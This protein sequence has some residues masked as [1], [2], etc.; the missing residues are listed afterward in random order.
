MVQ[1]PYSF[2]KS[3]GAVIGSL[4]DQPDGSKVC[5]NQLHL[6]VD[7]QPLWWNGGLLR[8]KNKSIYLLHTMLKV[9][10]GIFNHHA[11]KIPTISASYPLLNAP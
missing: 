10:I 6:G 4:D 5:G 11:S 8:D 9:K 3:Y 2:I 7:R 1:T